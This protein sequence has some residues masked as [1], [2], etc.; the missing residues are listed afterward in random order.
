MYVVYLTVYMHIVRYVFAEEKAL[1]SY[2]YTGVSLGEQDK[3]TVMLGKN[4]ETRL[5]EFKPWLRPSCIILSIL[6][7][8]VLPFSHLYWGE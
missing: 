6:T 1:E 7:L 8:F 3:V 2:G 5:N 4:S